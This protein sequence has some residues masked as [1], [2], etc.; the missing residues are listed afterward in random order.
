LTNVFREQGIGKRLIQELIAAAQ[1]QDY[2][3]IVGGI[4]ATNSVS[5]RLHESLGFVY[6]GA[7]REAGYQFGRWLD[8]SFYE[9]VLSPPF[10]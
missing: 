4:D 9:L 10:S 1:E 5:I 7:I 8:L 6:S 3:V 2:H